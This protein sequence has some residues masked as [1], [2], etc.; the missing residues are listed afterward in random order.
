M[1][2]VTPGDRGGAP[3]LEG[4]TRLPLIRRTS[5]RSSLKGEKFA[6][7]RGESSDLWGY[8]LI[9]PSFAFIAVVFLYPLIQLVPMSM[10]RVFGENPPFVGL[11]NY[12]YLLQDKIIRRAILNNFTLLL[13]IPVI[14][15]LSLFI[16][17]VLF[18][19][20]RGSRFYQAVVFF[21]YLLSTV[22]SSVMFGVLL[23]RNGVINTLLRGIG[24]DF[25]ALDWLGDPDIAIF[26]V[27]GVMT[28]R[29]TGFGTL[30]FLAGMTS[31]PSDVFDAA[32]VD[33]VSW[34]QKV[35]LVTIPQLKGLIVFYVIFLVIIIFSWS[36]NYVYVL[37]LGGPGFSTTILDFNIYHYAITK[38][39]PHMA[40]ALSIMLFM[41]ML[42]FIYLQFR[43]RRAQLE[44]E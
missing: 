2:L 40:A 11:D 12:A 44:P 39:L 4:P 30:L 17:A 7:R 41:S 6:V 37:T 13:A 18:E 27:M 8:L 36:F 24:L 1:A 26:T 38:R 21:P 9:L 20:G 23:Q 32:K 31:L 35:L 3:G 33:G 10:V 34:L 5:R 28:W 25:A 15:A 29:E 19:I 14:T 43:L 16:S 22:V 42:G